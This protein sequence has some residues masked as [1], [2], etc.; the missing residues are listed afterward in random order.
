MP[1]ALL[2]AARAEWALNYLIILIVSRKGLLRGKGKGG[3]G[4]RDPRVPK[5]NSLGM[6]FIHLFVNYFL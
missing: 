3:G 5:Q 1:R 4:G 6:H 2:P